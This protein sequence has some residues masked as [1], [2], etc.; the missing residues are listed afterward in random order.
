MTMLRRTLLFAY[1]VLAVAADPVSLTRQHTL[2]ASS[3]PLD[4]R[5]AS[6][7]IEFAYLAEFTGNKTNP[8]VLTKE[9][10]QRLVERTGVGPVSG[11]SQAC[12]T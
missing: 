6:F 2:Y 3:Q 11:P 8:N 4:S 9:L 5:L 12:C 1:A 10:M 7:S